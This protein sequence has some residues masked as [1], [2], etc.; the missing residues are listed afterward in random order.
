MGEWL[1]EFVF[2]VLSTLVKKQD[3]FEKIICSYQIVPKT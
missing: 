2:Y 1:A 3:L